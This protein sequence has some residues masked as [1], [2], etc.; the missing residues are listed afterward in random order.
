MRVRKPVELCV[1]QHVA[2]WREREAKARNVPRGRMIKD[3]ALYESRA[4]AAEV[5]AEALS[6]LQDN[7]ARL[8]TFASGRDAGR[9][10][11]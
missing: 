9:D 8:G 11:Q 4:A 7:P 5:D 10:R 3:D 6:R 1:L 2:A